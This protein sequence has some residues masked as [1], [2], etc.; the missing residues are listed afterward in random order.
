VTELTV[1]V[2]DEEVVHLA[3][4]SAY[5]CRG[6]SELTCL[7]HHRAE[8]Q[9]DEEVHHAEVGAE[10]EAGADHQDNVGGNAESARST[11]VTTAD[12]CQRLRQDQ[13]T[14]RQQS[15]AL[16]SIVMHSHGRLGLWCTLVRHCCTCPILKTI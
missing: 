15:N 14:H 7:Q 5:N 8:D 16:Y 11:W 4:V 10:G 1:Q 12:H 13:R 3:E 9:A 6:C 2:A